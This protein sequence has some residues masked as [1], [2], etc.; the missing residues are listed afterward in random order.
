MMILDR[1]S[2][3]TN[4]ALHIKTLSGKSLG[5]VPAEIS[6]ILNK[7]NPRDPAGSRTQAASMRT[8]RLGLVEGVYPV[9][10]SNPLI[11]GCEARH[12]VLKSFSGLFKY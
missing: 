7:V 6:Q 2:P 8:P 5:N 9:R 12:I 11:W 10:K 4:F 3:S 1:E